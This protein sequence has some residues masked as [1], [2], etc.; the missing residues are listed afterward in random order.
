MNWCNGDFDY[1]ECLSTEKRKQLLANICRESGGDEYKP[2]KS[3][4]ILD[5]Q[6]DI[7]K[8][9]KSKFMRR[10]GS[11]YYQKGLEGSQEYENITNRFYGSSLA[12]FT[13]GGDAQDLTL[14]VYVI[15][16]SDKSSDLQQQ[17]CVIAALSHMKAQ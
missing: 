9:N 14:E 3:S 7:D 8:S 1:C 15:D 2:K 16:E 5:E 4:E 17:S 10:I 6:E 11:I 13:S 12:V